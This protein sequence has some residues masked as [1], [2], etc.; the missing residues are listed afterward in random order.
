MHKQQTLIHI[1]YHKTGTTWLQKVLFQPTYGFSS[2]MSHE[3]VFKNIVR[4]HGLLFN[5]ENAQKLL[6][7]RRNDLELKMTG[8]ISSELLCGHPFYGGRESD[9]FAQH[10]YKIDPKARILITIRS[11]IPM[12][13]SVYMQYISRGGTLSPKVFF[14]NNPVMGYTRFAPEHFE[15]HRLIALYH[16]LFGRDNVLVM[17]QESLAKN[18]LDFAQ[19]IS[20]FTDSTPIDNLKTE[21]KVAISNPEYIACLLRRINHFKA[22]PASDEPIIDLGSFSNNLYR[23]AG[24]LGRQSMVKKLLKNVRPVREY[25]KLRFEGEFQESNR[26]LKDMLMG[27]IDLN[28]YHH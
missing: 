21:N 15:Y 11:Q 26:Q 2:L 3:E 14:S 17:T 1:G 10:L 8:I 9:Q 27:D 23:V 22:G 16:N 25:V 4:P 18:P 6:S 19:K 28:S 12:I 7:K 13:V 24:A 20:T 5:P